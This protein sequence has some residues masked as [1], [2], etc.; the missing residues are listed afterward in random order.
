LPGPSEP[1]M[2]ICTSK[3]HIPN[4]LKKFLTNQNRPVAV[5]VEPPGEVMAKIQC[6]HGIKLR[7]MLISKK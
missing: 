3:Y 2:P 4:S 7:I 1:K 6:C 5:R